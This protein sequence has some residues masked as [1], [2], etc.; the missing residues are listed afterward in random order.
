MKC[1]K[2]IALILAM[3]MVFSLAA[4]GGEKETKKNQFAGTYYIVGMEEGEETWDYSFL[5]LGGFTD[6]Y[7]KINEDGT[8]E[9]YLTDEEVEKCTLNEE[10]MSLDFDD[11]SKLDVEFKDDVIIITMPDDGIA[12]FALEGGK[13]LEE[14][15]KSVELLEDVL[16]LGDAAIESL[17]VS[18]AEWWLG[19]WYGWW[20]IFDGDGS[21][22]EMIN[23]SWDCCTYIEES[24]D[25]TY[26]ISIWD[27]DYNNYESN[28]LAEVNVKLDSGMTEKG[29]MVSIGA[30]GDYFW[31]G[32]V[33]EYDWNIDP[34]DTGTENMITINGSYI[35]EEGE[36]CEYGV[37]LTKWGYEWQEDLVFAP[38]YYEDY[39][40]P[41]LESGE[42]FLPVEFNPFS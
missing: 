17:N 16:A 11:G 38:D 37:V 5:S 14:A 34:Y 19:D 40:R 2:V 31:Y 3:A 9:V 41:L 12:R 21:Y 23:E 30:E 32:D 1:N 8:G 24:G 13:T 6:S 39:F 36:Y 26:L 4:C 22:E 27:E 33:L 28:C 15:K 7:V 29:A 25:G 42:T 20:T 18:D 10:N 35:D